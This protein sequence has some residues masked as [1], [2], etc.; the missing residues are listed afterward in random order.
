VWQ[1]TLDGRALRFV[2]AGINNQNF[3]MR[4]EETGSWWQQVTGEAIRGPLR[5]KRLAHV[6]HEEITFDRWRREFPGGRVLRPAAETAWVAFSRGWEEETAKFPVRIAASLDSVL[7]PREVVVGLDLGGRSRAYPLETLRRQMPL[8][9]EIAGV[10]VLLVLAGDGSLRGFDRR[11]G[12]RMLEFFA[13]T[14]STDL[15]L[16]DGPTGSVWDFTGRAV[17]GSLAGQELTPVYL[18]QDYWF[19]WKTYHPATTVYRR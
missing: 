10:P 12:G 5:G 7:P 18:Q 2:L 3:I 9:D 15:L 19:N 16:V 4:D 13:R 8:H 17:S 6:P 14:D 1:A 11:V